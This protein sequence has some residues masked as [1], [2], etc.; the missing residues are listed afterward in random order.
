MRAR[1]T[2]AQ[3]EAEG[4][5]RPNTNG[6]YCMCGECH[7]RA[8]IA[9][10][11]SRDRGLVKGEPRRFVHGHNMRTP[12]GR[13]ATARMARETAGLGRRRGVQPSPAAERFRAHLDEP[14]DNGC[15]RW[16]G[17]TA[18][19]G[20]GNFMRSKGTMVP[21][22]RFA[23]EQAY[24]PIPDGHEVHHR[25]GVPLCCN[26]EHLESLTVIEHRRRHRRVRPVDD[27][28]LCACGCGSPSQWDYQKGHARRFA[29]G[30]SLRARA[31]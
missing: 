18:R 22:H 5:F 26:P 14:D 1:I 7:E 15:V 17:G 13:A 30:H 20:Y 24:G 16:L 10:M 21:A 27:A 12:E 9:E 25:C 6:G 28:T 19:G 3:A 8:L 11:S 31:A 29:G 23:F 4:W 2:A